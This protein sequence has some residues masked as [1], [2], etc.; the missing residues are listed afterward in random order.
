[1][2][3][4]KSV[5][6]KVS[7]GSEQCCQKPNPPRAHGIHMGASTGPRAAPSKCSPLLKLEADRCARHRS[8]GSNWRWSRPR[9]R[10]PRQYHQ[11]VCAVRARTWTWNRV[12]TCQQG[13]QGC[14]RLREA[15][16]LEIAQTAQYLGNLIKL[17]PGRTRL[18]NSSNSSTSKFC[19]TRRDQIR[20]KTRSMRARTTC[21]AEW[22]QAHAKG[23]RM[24]PTERVATQHWRE[25]R[26]SNPGTAQG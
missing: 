6:L 10:R 23:R 17:V 11:I 8:G 12:P 13:Q 14:G 3:K 19:Q 22:S 1:M 4:C 24:E 9:R 26:N 5:T 16:K 2:L 7:W 15:K 25:R 20:K 21:W 18:P